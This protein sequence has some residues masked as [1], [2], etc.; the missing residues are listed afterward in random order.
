MKYLVTGGSYG[1][2]VLLQLIAAN[3]DSSQFSALVQ[4]L[5]REGPQARLEDTTVS[6]HLHLAKGGGLPNFLGHSPWTGERYDLTKLIEL[7]WMEWFIFSPGPDRRDLDILLSLS[8][9]FIYWSLC[10]PEDHCVLGWRF[11]LSFLSINGKLTCLFSSSS[12]R[13]FETVK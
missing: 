3:C 13:P 12:W 8:W 2:T 7:N 10:C 4:H 6:H 9:I 11:L 5:V 1:D